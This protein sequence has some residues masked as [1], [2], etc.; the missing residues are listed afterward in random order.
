MHI[1]DPHFYKD[2]YAGGSRRVD[3]DPEAVAPFTV[4]RATIATVDH[5]LH[6]VRRALLNPY[7]AK[8]SIVKLEP[9][10]QETI[11]RLCIRLEESM[12]QAQVV[13]LDSGFAAL[14]ADI[15]TRYFYGS[16]FDYLGSKGFKFAM[17]DAILGL[18]GFYHLTRFLPALTNTIKRL[19]IPIIRL[20]QP[21]AA[22]L[23]C[24]KA[25]IEQLIL[26]SLDDENSVKS[27]SVIF[28]A[29]KDP[30]VPAEEKTTDR[31]VDEGTSII[32]AGTEPTAK[33]LSVIMFHLLYNK[34]LLK[35]LRHELFTLA[36]VKDH[37]YQLSQLEA[38]PYLVRLP[39]MF[40]GTYPVHIT[41]RAALSMRAF[42]FHMAL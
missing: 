37:A 34:S 36:P 11:S 23:L 22:D 30:D 39:K 16:N 28:G 1:Y 10:I 15:I 19:P 3:K 41:Y 24:S 29:L 26:H 5:D 33:A 2:I 20:L 25:E 7:F 35:E 6:R 17:R 31:L 14:T 13:D 18:I 27:K 4:P 42:D 38:L 8:R 32:F 9:V 40:N 21:G 12:H